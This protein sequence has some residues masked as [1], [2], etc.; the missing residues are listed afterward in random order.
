MLSDVDHWEA[1]KE[2]QEEEPSLQG[3]RRKYGT[4]EVP[5]VHPM[6][7]GYTGWKLDKS[8]FK[9]EREKVGCYHHMGGKRK[10]RNGQPF[11]ERA[12]RIRRFRMD[13][14]APSLQ[15]EEIQ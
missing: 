4:F 10:L 2:I 1:E 14:G 5:V 12:K 7:F 6:A 11:L 3:S 9:R 8:G 13:L 15:V